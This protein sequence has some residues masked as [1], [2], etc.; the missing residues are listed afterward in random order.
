MNLKQA[1]EAIK[2]ELPDSEEV[3]QILGFIA[4]AKRGIAG[5]GGEHQ[6]AIT[7]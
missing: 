3:Q 2:A 1:V 5:L 6:G 7:D 4:R